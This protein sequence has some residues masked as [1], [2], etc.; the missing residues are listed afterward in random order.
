MN[1]Q[2]AIDNLDRS[3]ANTWS[4]NSRLLCSCLGV[5]VDVEYDKLDKRFTRHWIRSWLCTDTMVGASVY[6]CD[7]KPIA[8]STHAARKEDEELQFLSDE[9][10]ETT[11]QILLSI[12]VYDV[13][14]LVDL[15]EDISNYWLET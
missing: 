13:L 3:D 12:A 6:C 8:I 1:W 5:H 10:V 4:V 15:N 7:G 11:R 14:P 2:N 9:A